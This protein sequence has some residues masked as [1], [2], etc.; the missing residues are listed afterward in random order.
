MNRRKALKTFGT[1][2]AGLG[3]NPLLNT[4]NE[5]NKKF[6]KLKGNINHS[7]SAWCY[8]KLPFEELV[9]QSKKIGLVGID[10]VGSENWGVLKKYDMIST[11]CYGDLEGKSTRSLTNGWCDKSFHDELISNYIRHIK[12]VSDAGWKN[13]IC[14]S[15]SR[16][17]ISDEQGLKNCLEGLIKII[18][19]A[20]KYNVTLQMELLNSKVDHED[21]MCDNTRWGVELCKRLNS[22]N[23]KLIYDIYHMQI[24]EGDIIRTIR[25]NHKFFGHYHTAGVPGRN[26]ID[27]TQELFYPA[28]IKEIASTGFKG[29][30]AQ[31]FIPTRKDL[32]NGL[33]EAIQI[34]DI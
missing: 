12:L 11:M 31:E 1:G 34:C 8:K 10:L 27:E 28:V 23:F 32:M 21:Y 5:M 19:I 29:V 30:V 9:I 14:F 13:L 7:V 15:G 26:E 20:E 16:R 2:I 18:P 22:N 33:A 24:M 17:G 25:N 4:K 3:V 6:Y